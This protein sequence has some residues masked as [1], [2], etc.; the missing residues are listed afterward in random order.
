M[1]FL[2]NI[3]LTTPLELVGNMSTWEVFIKVGPSILDIIFSVEV[4]SFK[5]VHFFILTFK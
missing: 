2:K 4:S 3:L 5:N 1:V